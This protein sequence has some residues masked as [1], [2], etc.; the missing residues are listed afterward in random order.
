MPSEAF[1]Y[2]WMKVEDVLK[3]SASFYDRDCS[4]E[5]GRL[6]ERLKLDTRKK[7]DELSLGNRKKVNIV[8]A[9][10][11]G[12]KLY[13]L[14]E[15]TSGLDPLMQREFFE[16]LKERNESGASV[17]L[18]SHVLGEVE[19]Y[20]HRAAIIREGSIIAVDSVDKIRRSSARKVTV[21]GVSELPGIFMEKAEILDDG[22]RFFYR[23]E[24]EKLIG[25]LQGLPIR[26]LTI[27]EPDLEEVFLHF[28][29]GESR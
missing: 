16:I 7:V 19:R 23:G 28:Y 6:C 9:L 18:S 1:F 10:Q 14:D 25:A 4:E 15:P 2:S 5:C 27:T 12:A 20:C 26:D 21:R 3:F 29:E 13:V 8:C 11:H 17:F 22:V 24:M